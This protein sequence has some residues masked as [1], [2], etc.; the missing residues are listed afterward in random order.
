MRLERSFFGEIMAVTW[1][2]L[3]MTYSRML[4]F[5]T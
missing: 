1:A 5:I 4:T 2:F 3:V